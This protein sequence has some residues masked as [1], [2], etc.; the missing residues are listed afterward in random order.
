MEKFIELAKSRYSCRAYQS[1]P[2][3]TDQLLQIMETGRIAPSAVNYQ[4]WHFMVMTEPGSL[5]GLYPAYPRPWLE[6]APA[7]I[8]ICGDYAKGWR[9]PDGKNHTDMDIAIT[10]DHMTLQAAEL[11]LATCWICMFDAFLLHQILRLP[12]SITPLVMLPVG[13]PA[14]TPGDRHFTRKPIDEIVHWNSFRSQG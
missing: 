14:D 13:Y 7:I 4:P 6:T 1:T 3:T 11:G 10:V 5:A 2:V 9:R 12:A 8:V